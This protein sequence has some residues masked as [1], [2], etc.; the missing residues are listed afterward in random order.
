MGDNLRRVYIY[1]PMQQDDGAATN[2]FW[3]PANTGLS[4]LPDDQLQSTSPNY[5]GSDNSPVG[6]L[7]G[8][9]LRGM[10]ESRNQP[11][12][13]SS[14]TPNG[15]PQL[16]SDGY[17]APQ[18]GLLGR[19]VALQAHPYQPFAGAN[20]QVPSQP[21]DPNFRR[22]VG[23]LV[24]RDGSL[25]PVRTAPPID[26]ASEPASTL[27]GRMQAYWDHPQPFG[28]VSGLKGALNGIAQAV[29]G[30]IDATSVLST[31][32]EAFRQ[33]Q[34]RELGPSGA[35]NAVSL[36]AP[37]TPAAAGGIFARPLVNALRNG[38]PSLPASAG[39]A[40]YGVSRPIAAGLEERFPSA[41]KLLRD[42]GNGDL[43]G[44][45][46]HPSTSQVGAATLNL[47]NPMSLPPMTG[48]RFFGPSGEKSLP[49]WFAASPTMNAVQSGSPGRGISIPP[50]TPAPLPP[51]YMQ[52]NPRSRNTSRIQSR[53]AYSIGRGGG[54]DDDV[55]EQRKSD[56][57]GRC[58]EREDDYAAEGML[59]ACINRAIRRWDLCN[60]NGGRIPRF[61]P[62]EWS[63]R[64]EDEWINVSR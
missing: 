50:M 18:G 30:S 35:F 4:Q 53:K 60:R 22:L 7:L 58:Y 49:E 26:R 51:I 27:S 36:L 29:Q 24:G 41:M 42:A 17:G 32:E 11:A 61:E 62:P 54:D 55:C 20:G 38:L 47:Q 1:P 48:G 23:T 6:G 28:M 39:A 45:M 44:V 34:A 43:P 8:I 64:D 57:I 2:R 52:A 31:E 63:T 21:P 19:L 25:G 9:S 56:E 37:T 10:Q 12:V 13:D 40:G 15:A 33:N 14:L 16:D 59:Q 46:S 5:P 3:P